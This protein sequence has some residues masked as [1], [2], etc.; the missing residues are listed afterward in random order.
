M[1]MGPE[2]SW[3]LQPA[4][5]A[6]VLLLLLLLLWCCCCVQVEERPI[7]RERTERI[8]EHMPVEKQYVTEVK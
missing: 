1:A 5:A 6:V 8:V 7:V 3:G 4:A 2:T